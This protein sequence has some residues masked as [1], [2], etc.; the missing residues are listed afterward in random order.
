MECLISGATKVSLSDFEGCEGK[1]QNS[2]SITEV[3]CCFHQIDLDFDYQTQLSSKNF[4]SIPTITIFKA[5]QI[6]S[7]D[8]RNANFD[9]FSTLPPPSGYDL[10][11]VIQVFLI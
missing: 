10:I 3:C 9:L 8:N 2:S 1:S 5:V 11:K 6:L 4:K 7:F